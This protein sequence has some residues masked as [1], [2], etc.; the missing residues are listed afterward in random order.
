M[1]AGLAHGIFLGFNGMHPP[2]AQP[3]RC[4]DRYCP[5][6]GNFGA[7]FATVV[8]RTPKTGG[9]ISLELKP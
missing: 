4:G 3:E 2:A 9:E 5:A 1:I 6:I 8:I 7:L